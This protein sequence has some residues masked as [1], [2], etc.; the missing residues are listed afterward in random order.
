MEALTQYAVL[1]ASCVTSSAAG[2]CALKAR[3]FAATVAANETRSLG[4]RAV[5]RQ[6]GEFDEELQAME[7]VERG[8]S[9]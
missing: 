2:Y 7:A 4:N 5:L 9:S 8:R 1:T 3:A 6:A